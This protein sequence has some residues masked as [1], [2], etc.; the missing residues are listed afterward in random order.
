M[1]DQAGGSAAAAVRVRLARHDDP[2]ELADIG[3]ITV[4]AYQ[5]DG[6]VS[7]SQEYA[8]ELADTGR[9]A[10][11]AELLVAV[12]GA[13]QPIGT[14][15]VVRPGTPFAEISKPDELEFRMLAV[16]PAARRTGVAARLVQ[17][18]LLRARAEGYRRVVLSSTDRMNPA[19]RL[20]TRLGFQREPDRDWNPNPQVHL[21]AFALDL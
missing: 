9:R 19:H 1:S 4:Q 3:A 8:A 10:R 20:Y 13:E 15:T 14:V 21:L 16:H 11:D 7:A 18:V 5:V 6:H 17:E 2:G 12:T